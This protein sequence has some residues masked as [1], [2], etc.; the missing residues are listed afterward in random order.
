MTKPAEP[1]LGRFVVLIA[2]SVIVVAGMKA[3]TALVVPLFCAVF[4]SV[5][6]LPLL[7]WLG[8]IGLPGSIALILVLLGMVT[9]AGIVLIVIGSSLAG[10]E[11]EFTEYSESL[12]ALYSRVRTWMAQ[13]ID[14]SDGV[15][16]AID[17]QAL[18]VYI[19]Q[20]ASQLGALM[21]NVFVILLMV[22]FLLA[23]AGSLESKLREV[24]GD[25]EA[26]IARVEGIS[27]G[28][29]Q[30]FSIKIA[31]SFLTGLLVYALLFA[32][33]VDHPALWSFLAFL[34]NFVPNIGSFLAA[35]PAILLAL[36]QP[37]LGLGSAMVVMVGFALINVTIGSVL[38]PRIM[39][40]GLDLSNLV[41]FLSL[42]FWGWVLGPVGMLL[43]VPLT[44][45]AKIILEVFPEGRPIARLLGGSSAPSQ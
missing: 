7:R 15:H 1:S 41:V 32:V 13:Y 39:G 8:R 31:V 9:L 29:N 5:L 11:S 20:A 28:I 22:A 3:A 42:L 14:V 33:G 24:S 26:A 18:L 25:P 6:S 23:E 35:I 44:V 4:L 30:Y 16:S 27:H 34:L 10:F 21:S 45:A 2:S 37:E 19:G 38:E 17:P 43:S 36:V 12:R 40:K